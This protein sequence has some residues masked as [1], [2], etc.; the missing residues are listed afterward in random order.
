MGFE[1]G[2]EFGRWLNQ[3]EFEQK[4]VGAAGSALVLCTDGPGFNPLIVQAS[5]LRNVSAIRMVES[6]SQPFLARTGTIL[7]SDTRVTR[8]LDMGSNP[9]RLPG[10]YRAGSSPVGS[11]TFI[12][13]DRPFAWTP[14]PSYKST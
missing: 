4:L 6:S 13:P 14:R 2:F 11:K 1:P 3:R 5:A 7:I 10:A 8:G 12:R 9:V